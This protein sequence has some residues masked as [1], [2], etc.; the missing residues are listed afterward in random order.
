MGN[1]RGLVDQMAINCV[2]E[3]Q[4]YIISKLITEWLVMGV[5]FFL[6]CVRE[7]ISTEV[8][9]MTILLRLKCRFYTEEEVD[10]CD[11]CKD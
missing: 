7:S 3:L 8:L 4:S 2:K 10:R 6:N 9:S 1:L 11:A 5:M